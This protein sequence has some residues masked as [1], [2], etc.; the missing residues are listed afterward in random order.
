M[1]KE[2]TPPKGEDKEALKEEIK[3]LREKLLAQQQMV[4]KN[5]KSFYSIAYGGKVYISLD[6]NS[7][8][9]IVAIGPNGQPDYLVK[10]A[11]SSDPILRETVSSSLAGIY[12]SNIYYYIIYN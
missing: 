7:D 3:A 9:D 5:G 1:L 6:K 8:G 10:D 11:N 2:Y 4:N 12:T